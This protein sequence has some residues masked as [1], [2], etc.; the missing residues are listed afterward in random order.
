MNFTLNGVVSSL[1][2]S[3]AVPSL[4]F[5]APGSTT[6]I[7]NALDASGNT[8]VGSGS[9]VNASGTPVAVALTNGDST[10]A[11]ALSQ[12]SITQPGG[13]IGF[14]Y[15]GGALAS[16]TVTA[17]APGL[18]PAGATIA[19]VCSP[20]PPTSALFVPVTA[21]NF[22]FGLLPLSISGTS[23][24]AP[25]PILDPPG[26]TGSRGVVQ[27]GPV[28]DPAGHAYVASASF[29]AIEQFCPQASGTAAVPYRSV[30]LPLAWTSAVDNAR[31]LYV[32]QLGPTALSEFAPDSGSPGA[33]PGGAPATT[34][35]RT[36]SG[37][38]TEMAISTLFG[39]LP[40]LAV[41]SSNAYLSE[42]AEILVFG[43]GQTGNQAPSAT[44]A[45]QSPGLLTPQSVA[46]DTTGNVYVDYATDYLDQPAPSSF[47][48]GG[49][50]DSGAVAEYTAAGS[51]IRHITPQGV[52]AFDEP[53]A[54]YPAT[55]AV[56]RSGN[57][58][59][60][61][62]IY[63]TGFF[64]APGS[65]ENVAL[66]G[67]AATG[68][69]TPT[70]EF[71][72]TGTSVTGASAA[73]N[74]YTTLVVQQIA[75]D[76]TTGNIYACDSTGFGVLAYSSS[77]TLLGQILPS[78]GGLGAAYGIA[79]LPSGSF[80]VQSEPLTAGGTT[81]GAAQLQYYPSGTGTAGTTTA[82]PTRVVNL[83]GFAQPGLLAIDASGNIYE[84]GA[85]ALGETSDSLSYA[86][87]E[88]AANASPNAAP[89]STFLDPANVSIGPNLG[90]IAV[91]PSGTVLVGSAGSNEVYGY[92]AGTSGSNAVPTT[93]YE[94]YAP[95][96]WVAHAL[97]TDASGN[98]YAASFGGA[99]ITEFAAGTST[100]LRSIAGPHTR[101]LDIS[102]LAVDPAGNLYVGNQDGLTLDV[103][104]PSQ[105]GDVAPQRVVGNPLANVTTWMGF[106]I[107]PG[108]AGVAAGSASRGPSLQAATALAASA[109]ARAREVRLICATMPARCSRSLRTALRTSHPP[110]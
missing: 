74:G 5:E 13:P 103:F 56:D 19:F 84:L 107:G 41:T 18:A 99:T 93:S 106:G 102:S 73:P 38:A 30:V 8:I 80:V 62:F 87:A 10:G 83:G 48:P 11:T 23:P 105:N 88:F 97:A 71:T 24:G 66:Y 3:F 85:G 75:V 81:Y 53:F 77:G 49:V 96:T 33:P 2:A 72:M 9:F 86:V 6:L 70:T 16:D 32:F 40:T 28:V 37:P 63:S 57:L 54:T 50:N 25:S 55:I 67:P 100:I 14:T 20:P 51:L 29:A 78:V 108:A 110:M 58:W 22:G 46:V 44:I 92:A 26:I 98:L 31:N 35:L 104:G 1:S 45:D 17:S 89:I 12:S 52:L 21:T 109:S 76:P 59:V 39:G 69:A 36:I 64:G 34:P 27:S 101:L 4:P 65:D 47:N 61:N 60:A 82:A 7:V 90:G 91:S 79:F 15:N 43:A 95:S 94:D 42:N 68:N